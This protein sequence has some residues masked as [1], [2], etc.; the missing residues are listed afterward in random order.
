MKAFKAVIYLLAG[1]FQFALA[2]EQPRMSVLFV[3]TGIALI[4][5]GVLNLS[6]I[7]QKQQ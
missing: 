2:F 3:V 6:K 7:T 5:L 4:G 1:V